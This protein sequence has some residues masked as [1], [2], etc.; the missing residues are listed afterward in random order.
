MNNLLYSVNGALLFVIAGFA[1][2]RI[3]VNAKELIGI[4]KEGSAL[5]KKERD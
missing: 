1:V 4:V 5:A 2:Y 3:I